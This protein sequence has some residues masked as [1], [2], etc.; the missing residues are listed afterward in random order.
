MDVTK[1][2]RADDTRLL[3]VGR[4]A[5]LLRVQ[6]Q[7]GKTTPLDGVPMEQRVTPANG[8]L[9]LP[10]TRFRFQVTNVIAEFGLIADTL[11]A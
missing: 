9:T 10:S 3:K 11:V 5:H 4:H 8:I 2:L 7:F 6:I 1:T